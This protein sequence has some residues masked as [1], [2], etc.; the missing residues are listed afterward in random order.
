[1]LTSRVQPIERATN[2]PWTE[3]LTYLERIGADDLTHHAIAT[4]LLTELDGMVDNVGWW[5]QAIAV[6][7]EQH[8]G[9]RVPGQQ[10][11][12]TFRTSVSRSTPHEMAHLMDQWATFAAT[13]PDV[14]RLCC[15]EPRVSG[16]AN[17]ITWRTKGHHGSEVTVISEPKKNGS[18][19]LVVQHGGLPSPD[20]SAE[21]R[22]AWTAVLDR[23][24]PPFDDRAHG[25]QV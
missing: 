19:A 12:G 5:A 10:P 23:F 21:T 18:A 14:R 3:W 6:A 22:R 8:I 20:I 25:Q 7:Y 9:R 2:R 1:M 4:Q 17:R 11:D 13:D 16:T 15:A 24:L